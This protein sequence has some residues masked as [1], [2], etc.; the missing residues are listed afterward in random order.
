[1]LTPDLTRAAR[2]LLDWN[3]SLLAQKSNLSVSTVKDFESGRRTPAVNNLAAI[4]TAF[5]N[6]GIRFVTGDWN[7][8]IAVTKAAHGDFGAVVADPSW[9]TGVRRV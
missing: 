9:P 1:M 4:Q 6:A 3:Q 2:G 7:G 5:E 8:G